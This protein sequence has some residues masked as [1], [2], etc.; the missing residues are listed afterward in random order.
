MSDQFA[1]QPAALE[2]SR[3]R[4]ATLEL[5]LAERERVL[6]DARRELQELQSRYLNAVGEYYAQLVEIEAEAVDLEVKLGLRPPVED[7]P[8][9]PESGPAVDADGCSNRGAA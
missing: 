7:D 3:A 5:Q 4:L 2:P 6:A 1:L 9:E 8:V